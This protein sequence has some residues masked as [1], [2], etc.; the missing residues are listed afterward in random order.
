MRVNKKVLKIHELADRDYYKEILLKQNMIAATNGHYAVKTIDKTADQENPK[1]AVIPAGEIKNIYSLLNTKKDSL[2]YLNMPENCGG[3]I[4]MIEGKE[5]DLEIETTDKKYPNLDAVYKNAKDRIDDFFFKVN[6]EYMKRILDYFSS[7]GFNSVEIYLPIDHPGAIRIENENDDLKIEALLMP[8]VPDNINPE[9]G[10]S[11]TREKTS[12]EKYR[13]DALKKQE[14]KE[15][16]KQAKK[17]EPQQEKEQESRTEK[18]SQPPAKQEITDENKIKIPEGKMAVEIDICFDDSQMM[19]DYYYPHRSISCHLLAIVK[20]QPQRQALARKIHEQV[21]E[22]RKLNWSWHTENYSGGHGNYL[23][24]EVVGKRKYKA[25]DGREEVNCWYEISFNPF[26]K[27]KEAHPKFYLGD[28]TEQ[29]QPLAQ[30]KQDP[31]NNG[32]LK[33]TVR[34]NS[35]KKGIE[36]VFS[37]KPDNSILTVLKANGWRWSRFAGLWYNRDTAENLKFAESL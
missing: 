30:K 24:S 7:N 12:I 25:Y 36:I 31:E 21:P 3:P 32:N 15:K 17:Q 19:T 10:C 23:M 9:Y 20:E 5:K 8:V 34:K 13:K 18:E 22:L 33:K 11:I 6:P 37:R 27:E 4:A 26:A 29:P 28:L 35:K 14:I 1:F 16:L 2:N